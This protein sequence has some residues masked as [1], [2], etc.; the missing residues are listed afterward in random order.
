MIDL[1][2]DL[3]ITYIEQRNYVPGWGIGPLGPLV[4]RGRAP[5]K[6]RLR[7]RMEQA[8]GKSKFRCVVYDCDGVLF[9]SLEANRRFYSRICASTGRSPLREEELRYAHSHTVRESIDLIFRDRPDLT[10]KAYELMR[11]FDQK[12]FLH[13]LKMEPNLLPALKILGEEGLLRAVNTNRTTSMKAIMDRFDL[14]PYFDLVVT[15]L[16][17]RN[18][19]PD[20]ES[21]EKI[22]S[23]FKLNREE[24]VFVGDSEVD[25]QTAR[26]SGIRFI[27]YKNREIATDGFIEDHLALIPLLFEGRP[28][29]SRLSG[30]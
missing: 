15:A 19:K 11:K 10:G 23:T 5:E 12:E 3:S 1:T 22:I 17:V 9:D 20:P 28:A 27:A 6:D 29:G 30:A 14:W 18:P 13:Y 26:A 7:M 2:L 16:D 21:I 25:R 4:A 24:I 8:S